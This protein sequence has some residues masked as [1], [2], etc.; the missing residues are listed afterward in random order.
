MAAI[1]AIHSSNPELAEKIRLE[2]D[3][4]RRNAERMRYPRFRAQHL[5]GFIVGM[6]FADQL[7]WV[8]ACGIEIDNLHRAGKVLLG[9]VPD[10]FRAVVT[11][12]ELVHGIYRATTPKVGQRRR[13]YIE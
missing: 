5:F 3:Y 10:P 9:K 1:A 4:F 7:P 12:A 2:A 13:E 11:V 8:L 6:E